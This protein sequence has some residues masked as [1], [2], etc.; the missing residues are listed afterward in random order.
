VRE[1]RTPGSERAK[2]EWLSYSTI[3]PCTVASCSSS[4]R[5]HEYML[6]CAPVGGPPGS[7]W[8]GPGPREGLEHWYWVAEPS[9][10]H[11]RHVSCAV[12]ASP[13]THWAKRYEIPNPTQCQFPSSQRTHVP[14]GVAQVDESSWFEGEASVS[15][16]DELLDEP[17]LP[18]CEEP[19]LDGLTVAPPPSATLT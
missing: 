10:A 4:Q 13:G 12:Q 8:M 14:F 11:M 19:P 1:I 15:P 5:L 3:S 18:P 6:S 17:L 2:A 7:H 9:G 16:S